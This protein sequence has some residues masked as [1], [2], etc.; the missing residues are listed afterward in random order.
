MLPAVTFKYCIF[1]PYNIYVFHMILKINSN[2]LNFIYLCQHNIID[3][4]HI[5][6]LLTYLHVTIFLPSSG[7]LHILLSWL[8]SRDSV[9]GIATG[10]GLDDRRVGVRIPVVSRI[11][12]SQRRPDRLWSPPNL[13]S[14]GYRGPFPRLKRPDRKGDHS[15]PASV[16]VKKMW[17]YIST[18]PYAF[19]A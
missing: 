8:W 12:T 11:F 16:E 15:P 7:L 17:I 9:V 14:N 6:Y 13:L 2:Y 4:L 1:F 10:Y 18:P 5:I 3:A 19:R